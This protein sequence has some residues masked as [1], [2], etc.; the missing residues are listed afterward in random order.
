M[1]TLTISRCAVAVSCAAILAGCGANG[2]NTVGTNPPTTAIPDAMPLQHTFHYTGREQIFRVPSGIRA[3]TVVAR[4]AAGAGYSGS[5]YGSYYE[6]F[7]LGGRVYAVIPVR[8]GETL[9]VFVGGQGSSKGGF[10]GGGS[11]G[12]DPS[13]GQ[14]YGGGGASDVRQGGNAVGDRILVAAGGGGEG[15]CVRRG[16]GVGGNGGAEVGEAG[17][18]AYYGATGGGGGAQTHGGRGGAGGY[19]YGTGYYPGFS[20][21][22]GTFGHGGAGG[23]GGYNGYCEEGYCEGGG[24]GG[25]GGGYYGGGGGGGGASTDYG[26]A[27]GEPG[28][29]GGGGSSYVERSA[30]RT[31][32][33]RGWKNANTNGL[34]VFSWK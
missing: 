5:S 9:Y 6:Y 2:V 16:Q 19:G 24:G 12:V 8:S 4:G 18:D 33:W 10:N 15:C 31:R 23:N 20:G 13:S 30:S 22:S 11:P 32:L 27:V 34:V 28:A 7:G 25:G 14:G 21:A 3:I 17:A 1:N 26:S 29:G